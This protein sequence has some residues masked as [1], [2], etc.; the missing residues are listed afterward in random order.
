MPHARY[1]A[2]F[3]RVGALQ[4]ARL[5]QQYEEH[6]QRIEAELKQSALGTQPLSISEFNSFAKDKGKPKRSGKHREEK[7]AKRKEQ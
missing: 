2:M 6:A 5:A 3:H 1:V 7:P 4:A